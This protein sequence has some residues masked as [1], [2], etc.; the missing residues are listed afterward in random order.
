MMDTAFVKIVLTIKKIV[1]L[2]VLKRYI[3]LEQLTGGVRLNATE[4]EQAIYD[5]DGVLVM[6]PD[7]DFENNVDAIEITES[8]P[9]SWSVRYDL[10]TE[11]EGRSDLSLE[12]TLID[13]GN[14]LM[15]VELDNIH[16]L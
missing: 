5:Y 14:E 2:L 4:I 16:V 12:V 8:S 1:E 3:E 9:K 13:G 15:R 7:G 6:P 11:E 10:W